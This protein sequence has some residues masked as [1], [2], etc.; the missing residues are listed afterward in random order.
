MYSPH[1]LLMSDDDPSSSDRLTPDQTYGGS[2]PIFPPGPRIPPR[3]TSRQQ[4]FDVHI[5]L[6]AHQP[7]RRFISPTPL[8]YGRARDS[9]TPP[10]PLN[11]PLFRGPPST[12]TTLDMASGITSR[13]PVTNR[14]PA[15]RRSIS[16]QQIDQENSDDVM[17][18]AVME[19]RTAVR[20][21]YDGAEGGEGR[22]EVMNETPPRVGRFERHM[23]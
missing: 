2:A 18:A 21:R 8:S 12:S 9:P 14:A 7:T 1:P 15:L 11:R 10:L 13:R 3:N 5:Q 17:R 16:R 19:E 22:G 4:D 23:G 6:P 20:M